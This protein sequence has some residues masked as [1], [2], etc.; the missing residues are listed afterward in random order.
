MIF[1]LTEKIGRRLALM[2]C[3]A[4]FEIGSLIQLLS[5]GSLSAI[6]AGRFI[7]G[8]G[9][10]AACLI[11]PIYIA[12]ISPPAIRGRLVGFFEI[13]FQIGAVLVLGVSK[14]IKQVFG[15]WIPYGVNRNLASNNQQWYTTL[16]S[17]L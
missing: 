11:V 15:F 3:A 6:Y 13:M 17:L 5:F 12:E 8:W 2:V 14:L 9:V 4:V 1:P 10:G 16:Q 7:G